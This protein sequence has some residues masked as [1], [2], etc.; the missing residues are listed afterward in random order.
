MRS[1]SFP[2][3]A[4]W[5]TA[6][7][8][9]EPPPR[10]PPC[11]IRLS[12]ETWARSPASSSARTIRFDPSVGT[13]CGERTGHVDAVATRGDRDQVVEIEAHHLGVEQ[14]EAVVAE[15]GHLQRAGELGVRPD[16]R[17]GHRRGGSHARHRP[18]T[19]LVSR[20]HASTPSCSGRSVGAMSAAANCSGETTPDND[21]RSILRRW[22]N[23]VFTSANSASGSASGGGRRVIS[24]SAGLDVR[25][26]EE[27]AG[28]H[29]PDD[30]GVAPVRRLDADRSVRAR[31]G[32]G[33]E[34][35]GDLALDHHEDAVDV[36]DPVEHVADHRRADVVRQVRHERPPALDAR[37]DQRRP[38]GR[39]GVGL[40]HGHVVDAGLG[41]DRRQHRHHATVDL[42][43][44]DRRSGLGEGEG[45]RP[46]ARADL[47]DVIAGSRHERGRRSAAR[48]S[49][50]RRSS[51]RGRDV[52]RGR[53]RRA[54]RG[55]PG[56]SG[57]THRAVR[58]AVRLIGSARSRSAPRSGRPGAR[59]CRC[60]ARRLRPG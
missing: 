15:P 25:L 19:T 57:S 39:H 49:G 11:G 42:D 60:G 56:A 52:G 38:V 55:S 46:E 23:A 31:P 29:V 51:A 53:G 12:T 58:R 7:A 59:R 33:G 26:R 34:S 4:Q 18:A 36:G 43:G 24:T 10:P 37:V 27:H 13:P 44:R 21:L 9:V 28:R 41:D 3:P 17:R 16:R 6:A 48:C 32:G 47:D 30:A 35:F 40:D 45:Q 22:P 14:V 1:G 50:R 2:N 20:T 5:S 54:A 8:S